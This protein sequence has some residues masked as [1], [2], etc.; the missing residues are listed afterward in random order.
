MRRALSGALI[1]TLLAARA[2]V[3]QEV[4]RELPGFDFTPDGVWRVK[5]RQVRALREQLLS[6]GDF[7]RLNAPAA[8]RAPAWSAAAVTDTLR[9]PAILIRFRDTDTTTQRDTAQYSQAIFA[10]VPP[11]G[12][13]YTL[14]TFYEEM[15]NRLFSIQGQAI[16][17]VTLTSGEA[18]YVGPASGC[19]PFGTCNGV[20]SD[21]AFSALQAGLQE[22]VLMADPG[23]D[24]GQFDNDGP[25]G[26]PNSQDDDGTVDIVLFVH[27]SPD[28][29]CRGITNNNHPWSHRSSLSVSTADP[30]TAVPGQRIRVT[31]YIMQSGLGGTSNCDTTQIMAIGTTAH[32]LGH[33]LGLP[34]FYDTN[35]NDG[36]DSEGIGQ[37][38]LM[39]SGNYT[40]ATSPSYMESFSRSQLGW[41]TVRPLAASD[42]Y[43]LGP[44]TSR[45]TAML[46]RPTAPNPRGEYFLLENRQPV[47]SDTAMTRIMGPGLL[48]W[49]FDSTQYARGFDVNSGPIHALWLMQADGLNQ[50]RSSVPSVR[51]RGDAG[52]PYPGSTDN[53]AF[54]LSTNPAAR[55]NTPGGPY[56]GF[57]VDSI[58]QVV[59]NGE[60]AFRLRFGGLSIVRASDT[61]AQVRVRGVAYSVFQDVFNAGDTL[62]VS[63]DSVQ[64]SADV[65]RR[66]T[67]ASWS[68]EGARTHLL[69]MTANGSTF[70]AFVNRAFRLQVS[71]SGLA[72]PVPGFPLDTFRV[73][74]DSVVLDAGPPPL[75][76]FA[77]WT[78]DTTAISPRIVVRMTRPFTIV[79]S[80]SPVA[81]DSVVA[82]LTTGTGLSLNQRAILDAQGNQDGL[83]DLGDFVAWLDRS[84]TVV[85]AATMARVLRG[86][87]P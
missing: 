13:P 52:D 38:G 8:L 23:V 85:G 49:H 56:A 76:L 64:T 31:N 84:G 74:N 18:Q 45:D 44:T 7:A 25:D 26:V 16:G 1:V 33:G 24:F 9:A 47:L 29:A 30:R 73:E 80:Y 34:D 11:F 15:S 6:R 22:A 59:L 4:R 87:R 41:M 48:V 20:W 46:V 68:D 75:T 21:P 58:L 10:L 37:W 82:Q 50:L 78:G 77:G 62:T 36:D 2:A 71:V 79:A 12:R 55:L 51:N 69:T 70:T 53:A 32:E 65:R 35:Q 54:T 63:V 14:R 61:L 19:T 83:F 57:L 67:F 39:G 28:G 81:L 17:W 66:F 5:A 42:T 86:A 27:A 40:T 43:T 72:T 3:A 60:M